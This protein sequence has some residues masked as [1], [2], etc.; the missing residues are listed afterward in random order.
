MALDSVRKHAE[1]AIEGGANVLILSDRALSETRLP[2]PALLATS[3]VHHHLV[4]L[5]IR[6]QASIVVESGEPREIHHIATLIGFGASAVNPYLMLETRSPRSQTDHHVGAAIDPEEACSRT[7]EALDAGL[8][9]VLSKMG[10]S[11]IQSYCA[12]QIFEAVGLEKELIDEHFTG[13][14]SNIGGMKLIDLAREVV[15]R[16]AR[17]W[18]EIH[19]LALPSHVEEAR[20]P[21]ASE[22]L[23]PQGGIYAWRRD[24]ERHMW[25]PETV[26]GLQRVARGNGD[27]RES[28]ELFAAPRQRRER[29]ARPDPRPAQAAQGRAGDLAR[30]GAAG[31]RDRDPLRDRRDEPRRALA[32]RRTRRWRWR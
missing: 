16:H 8:L 12:A 5:G 21:A 28:Y 22:N 24:A 14:P 32:R 3:S 6:T 9:K 7:I 27:R 2:I 20:L 18:P 10:I 13:T 1:R 29:Q 31:G 19:N 23:L 15:D 26:A 25:E 4:R 30:R 17:A 11:T